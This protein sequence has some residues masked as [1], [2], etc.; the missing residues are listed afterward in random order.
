[1]N[2][3]HFTLIAVSAALLG[4][5]ALARPSVSGSTRGGHTSQ[6]AGRVY[7]GTVSGQNGG[8][9]NAAGGKVVVPG[10]GAARA[11]TYNATGP[12]GGSMQ[13]QG[14]NVQTKQGGMHQNTGSWN[15]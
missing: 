3:K 1:M 2:L 11:G 13:S 9:V 15:G 8:T 12:N 6:G 5:T 14:V 7:Q 4:G 10:K